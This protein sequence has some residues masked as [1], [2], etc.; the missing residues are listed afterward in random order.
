M[1]AMTPSTRK[2]LRATQALP[3]FR[4]DQFSV[5]FGVNQGEPISF[6]D[7]LML[8]DV[9]ELEKKAEPSKLVVSNG[10][11][12]LRITSDSEVGTADCQIIVDCT[13]TLMS[14]DGTTIE[15]L[16]L[17]EVED[18]EAVET[19]L[20]PLAH[21]ASR[22]EYTLVGVNRTDARRRFA[23]AACV[24]FTRGTHITMASGAQVPI[25]E[26]RVGDRVLTRDEGPREIRWIGQNTRRAMGEFAPVLI[27]KGTLNNENDL[28]VSSDHRLFIYQR[29]DAIGAGRSEVLVKV[30]HLIN[31]DSVRR[32]EGGFVDY[33]QLLFDNHQIIY[34]EGIAA[35]S[36]L[37]DTRTRAALP[38]DV[39]A[40]LAEAMGAH[41]ERHHLDYEV[42]E[43]LLSPDAAEMLRRA[44]TR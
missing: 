10:S 9:Y 33:F 29:D 43:T 28:I 4:G 42:C 37:V 20:M 13:V 35:E 7:E 24:A 16:V 8:D 34:A 27:R 11:D 39:D 17:V 31:G 1:N 30:R 18:D 41:E 15:G 19:Y 23:E 26:L 12:E 14:P 40:A 6:A 5:L 2:K 22:M 32:L 38:E 25:E 44:S 3:V 21:L 36:L